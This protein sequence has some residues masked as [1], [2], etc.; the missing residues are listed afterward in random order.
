L[1][2]HINNEVKKREKLIESNS[3]Q[4]LPFKM[5]K[6]AVKLSTEKSNIEKAGVLT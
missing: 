6:R 3:N 1:K 2:I 5:L 4:S